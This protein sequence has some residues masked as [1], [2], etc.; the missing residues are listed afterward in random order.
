M[1]VWHYENKSTKNIN[2]GESIISIQFV[3]FLNLDQQSIC[4]YLVDDK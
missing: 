2:K 3:H 4:I 1:L